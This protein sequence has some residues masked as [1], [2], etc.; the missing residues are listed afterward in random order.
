MIPAQIVDPVN[1]GVYTR[2]VPPVFK[3]MG[4]LIDENASDDKHKFLNLMGRQKFYNSNIYQYYVVSTNRDENIKFDLGNKY[5]KELYSGDKIK[6]H[7]LNNREYTVH[8]DK[9][10]DYEYNPYII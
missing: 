8:I 2:G 3:K 10:V 7:Q 1:F 6:I 5:K 9:D 4:Y